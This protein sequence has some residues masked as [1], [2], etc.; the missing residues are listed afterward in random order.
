MGKRRIRNL[1]ELGY[2]D[3]AGYDLRA[4]RI[5]EVREQYGVAVFSEFEVAL[6][7]YQPDIFIIST[8][9]AS[10]MFYAERA[11]KEGKHCFIEASVVERERVAALSELV[12]TKNLIFAPS[13]TMRFFPFANLIREMLAEKKI[14]KILYFT[15]VVGQYLEDWHP[16]ETIK[17]FY[18]SRKETGGA[19]EIVPF[20]LGWLF[21]IF[22]KLNPLCCVKKKLSDLDADIDDFYSFILEGDDGVIGTIN[23]EVLSR[24]EATR[25]FRVVGER[26]IIEFDGRNNLVSVC[27]LDSNERDEY[28]LGEGEVFQGYI[29]PE[30]PYV[31]ELKLFMQA[32]VE[33][34]PDI[35]PNSLAKDA[36]ILS[37][38]ELLE[39][40]TVDGIKS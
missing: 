8:E 37:V 27:D 5:D 9:P 15:Y 29:N 3:L 24:P 30:E 33:S 39:A 17:D 11:F 38:L 36:Y 4:D 6:S 31:E 40:M 12:A 32:V 1:F 22:G 35:F 16:W 28:N 21:E 19:R 23:V 34:R 2:Q 25:N 20:E 14:G 10:H 7:E 18:V 26:G 13:I